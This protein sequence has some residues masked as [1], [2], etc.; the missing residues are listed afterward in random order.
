MV[1]GGAPAGV[2]IFYGPPLDP[3]TG[4]E[5]DRG[6]RWQAQVNGQYEELERVWPAC[7]REPIDEAEYRFMVRASEHA[8]KHDGYSPL[9]Q[10]RKRVDWD[11]AT[12]PSF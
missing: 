11:S 7:M 9:G 12:P 1:R 6:H 2:R 5:M 8:R 10:P 3:V 4:E